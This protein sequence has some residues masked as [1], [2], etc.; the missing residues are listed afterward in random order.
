METLC[1]GH[2]RAPCNHSHSPPLLR[3]QKS[4][5]WAP[6]RSLSPP[7]SP[8]RSQRLRGSYCLQTGHGKTGP[9]FWLPPLVDLHTLN[10]KVELSIFADRKKWADGNQDQLCFCVYSHPVTKG[11]SNMVWIIT[12]WDRVVNCD[13]KILEEH[14]EPFMRFDMTNWVKN[15]KNRCETVHCFF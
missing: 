14:L 12:F 2:R 7:K 5:R 15:N 3:S 10:R 4:G 6:R 13:L 8:T 9:W 1:Q 11:F